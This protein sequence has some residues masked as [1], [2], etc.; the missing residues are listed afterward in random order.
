MAAP[1]AL[2]S[3]PVRR[4]RSNRAVCAAFVAWIGLAWLIAVVGGVRAEDAPSKRDRQGPVTVSVA[5]VALPQ[6]GS[7][8]TVR[9]VLDTHS[10]SLDAVAFDRVVA[11]RK[12]DGSDAPPAGVELVTGSGHHRQAEVVFRLPEEASEVRIVVRNVGG[13]PERIF[14]WP[15]PAGR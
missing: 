4:R 10:E 13:V 2:T 3:T 7:S 15:V 1:G 5:L 12:P 14:A 11:L 8:V 9:V 6:P